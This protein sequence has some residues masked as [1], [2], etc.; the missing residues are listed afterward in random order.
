MVKTM[1]NKFTNKTGLLYFPDIGQ[2]GAENC[3]P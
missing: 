2:Q 1:C 3:D